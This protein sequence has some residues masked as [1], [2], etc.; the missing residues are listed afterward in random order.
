MDRFIERTVREDKLDKGRGIVYNVTATINKATEG[1]GAFHFH[2]S[3]QSARFVGHPQVAWRP[4]DGSN[5][6]DGRFAFGSNGGY[7]Q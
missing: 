5:R 7:F 2:T 3:G 4:V 6:G 1:Q